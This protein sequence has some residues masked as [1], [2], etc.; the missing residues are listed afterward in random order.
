MESKSVRKADIINILTY[1]IK[2]WFIIILVGIVFAGIMGGYQFYKYK[3]QRT[4]EDYANAHYIAPVYGSFTV[5]ISNYDGS[6]NYYNRIEDVTAIVRSYDSL[7]KLSKKDNIAVNYTTMYNCVAVVNVGMNMLEISVEGS[8]IGYDQEGVVKLAKD[9]SEIVMDT[10]NK[11][12]GEGS[13]LLMDEPHANAYVLQKSITLDESEVKTI[14]KKGVIKI[15]FIGGVIG[16][17]IGAVAVLFA[18]LLSTV[19]RTQQEVVECYELPLLGAINHN[20][21]DEEE[22]KRVLLKIEDDKTIAVI[23]ATDREYRSEQAQMLCKNAAVNGKTALL[24]DIATGGEISENGL[25]RLCTGKADALS[26]VKDTDKKSVKKVEW[27]DATDGD[28]DL[29]TNEKFEE[30]LALFRDKFDYVFVSCPAMLVSA[31]ALGT[32]L[33]CDGVILTAGSGVV[34][35]E[36]ANRVKLNLKQNGICCD[37]L[38]YVK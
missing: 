18:L 24:V 38:I 32:A 10:F 30:A 7:D 11:Q 20:A 37:G 5:Y 26:M 34:R 31:A 1:M 19:L 29:F 4:N 23:S 25:Y 27:T 9:L 14:T 15:A 13:V 28:I 35:E 3:V 12:L 33:L 8:L 6:E 21:V 36:D 22:Y 17:V 16:C 2:K